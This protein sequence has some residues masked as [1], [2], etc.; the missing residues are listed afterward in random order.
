MDLL[1]Y[2]RSVIPLVTCEP[3]RLHKTDISAWSAIADSTDGFQVQRVVPSRESHAKT[4]HGEP[5]VLRLRAHEVIT[6]TACHRLKKSQQSQRTVIQMIV[7]DMKQ[8]NLSKLSSPE[9]CVTLSRP[10]VA[11]A[12]DIAT[13]CGLVQ[14]DFPAE[15]ILPRTL[16]CKKKFTV[17]GRWFN[18]F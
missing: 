10:F 6:V 15:L 17:N 12:V 14:L 8:P 11:Y 13:E 1:Y 2:W 18:F 7:A 5:E 9:K 16:R 3:E 4:T